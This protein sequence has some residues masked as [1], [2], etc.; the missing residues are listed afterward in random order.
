MAAANIKERRGP[1]D[2]D[3]SE[4]HRSSRPRE[5]HG[6]MAIHS[7]LSRRRPPTLSYLADIA[8]S[9][10]SVGEHGELPP[11][12]HDT[13]H[14]ERRISKRRREGDD[15]DTATRNQSARHPE[16]KLPDRHYPLDEREDDDMESIPSTMAFSSLSDRASPTKVLAS[17]KQLPVFVGIVPLPSDAQQQLPTAQAPRR[18]ERPTQQQQERQRSSSSPS[19]AELGGTSAADGAAAAET[20]SSASRRWRFPLQLLQTFLGRG[21][22]HQTTS[23]TAEAEMGD[24]P[25]SGSGFSVVSPL[26]AVQSTGKLTDPLLYLQPRQLLQ[27]PV[28]SDASVSLTSDSTIAAA[29]AAEPLYGWTGVSDEVALL[30]PGAEEVAGSSE[31]AARQSQRCVGV[32]SVSVMLDPTTA[33]SAPLQEWS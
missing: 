16:R 22:D 5:S 17:M 23:S 33:A 30:L 12:A 6:A 20:E 3:D 13:H 7:S 8:S 18:T 26:E 10:T 29:A 31:T 28:N 9:E 32:V 14:A 1:A 4:G 2:D 24:D 19:P 11:S 25:Q 27:L 21:A 15:D